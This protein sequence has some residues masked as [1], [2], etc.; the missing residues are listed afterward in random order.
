VIEA[1]QVGVHF[2]FDRHRRVV[3]SAAAR[4]RRIGSTTWGLRDLSFSIGPGEAVALLGPSGSGKTTLL[5]L[6]A[7]VYEPD[8]GRIDIR[9]NVAS[10]LSVEAG[11][12]PLLTGR[13]N[14]LHLGVLGGMSR[15][16]ARAA[17][18]E[19]KVRSG[20][21]E[22]FE[23][24]VSSYS[25]GMRAR[26]GFGVADE[27]NP[28][29]MV[30]DEV[31]EALDHEFR[32]ILEQRAHALV[33]SGGIVVAAGHDHPMLERLC[34]RAL[35]L[36]HGSLRADGPFTDVQRRYLDEVHAHTLG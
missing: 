19:I 33:A 13:E 4:F 23:R 36:S 29:V 31:H 22:Y 3:T 12:L 15:A 6:V 1:H 7:G 2:L 30:L 34:N 14:A 20:L 28:R 8:A 26:L 5:R 32:E 9:G 35:Y 18:E 10:L 11:L 21:D 24:P 17:L 27:T 16:R 25:Q